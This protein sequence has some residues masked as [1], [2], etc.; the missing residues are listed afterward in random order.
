MNVWIDDVTIQ[1][2]QQVGGHATPEAAVLTALYWYINR[3]T[4]QSKAA[5]PSPVPAQ[6]YEPEKLIA[7]FGTFDL[8][9]ID[10]HGSSTSATSEY[11]VP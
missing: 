1:E 7:Q 4:S 6:P 2:A 8:E 3:K 5:A 9:P 10:D 11:H